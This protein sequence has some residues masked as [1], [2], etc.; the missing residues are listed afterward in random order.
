METTDYCLSDASAAATATMPDVELYAPVVMV[1]ADALC[2]VFVNKNNNNGSTRNS[3][4]IP[5][6]DP[7]LLLRP[8]APMGAMSSPRHLRASPTS[9]SV[10]S[11][12]G[13]YQQQQPHPSQHHHRPHRHHEHPQQEHRKTSTS[14]FNGLSL[15][16][17]PLLFSDPNM[18]LR[19]DSVIH[20]PMTMN[21]SNS[22]WD[23]QSSSQTKDVGSKRTPAQNRVHPL[24]SGG[25][26]AQNRSYF[27]GEREDDDEGLEAKFRGI[28][29]S[30]GRMGRADEEERF[31]D[32]PNIDELFL[33]N[34]VSQ[35]SLVGKLTTWPGGE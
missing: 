12:S 1:N 30:Q 19:H 28:S 13:P 10:N 31:F 18:T 14:N 4:T 6:I 32:N 26:W 15:Q 24:R 17:V 33:F 23:G 9:L 11:W 5:L 20:S 29:T 8:I 16:T 3:P 22:C 35:Q 25:S 21:S 7:T 27:T 2:P 34:S